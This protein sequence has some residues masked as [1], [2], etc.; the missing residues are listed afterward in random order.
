ML[1]VIN[2]FLHEVIQCNTKIEYCVKSIV[3]DSNN[4]VI[5]KIETVSKGG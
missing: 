3:S 1:C 5:D 2:L 4:W